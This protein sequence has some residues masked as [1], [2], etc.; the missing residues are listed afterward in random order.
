MS[1]LP[2]MPFTFQASLEQGVLSHTLGVLL[3]GSARV[4]MSYKT[5]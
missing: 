3:E 1:M 2:W 5:M 4:E